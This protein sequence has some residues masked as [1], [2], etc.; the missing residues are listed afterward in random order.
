LE[1]IN[2]SK[3][4]TLVRFIYALGIRNVGEATAKTYAALRLVDNLLAA[5]AESLQQVRDV[6]LWWR[7][8]R[9]SG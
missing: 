1:K 7:R 2:C 6:G 5:D 8:H 4:T 3:Q 9:F